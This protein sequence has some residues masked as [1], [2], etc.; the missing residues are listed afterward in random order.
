VRVIPTIDEEG[1]KVDETLAE[2][3]EV[4]ITERVK[5]EVGEG[6][7]EVKGV[8]KSEKEPFAVDVTVCS[9]DWEH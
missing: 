9:V 7:W 3:W 8:K 5:I 1:S 6:L 4:G 2:G